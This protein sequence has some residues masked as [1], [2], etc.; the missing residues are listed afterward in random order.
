MST[1]RYSHLLSLE[2]DSMQ[3]RHIC[4]LIY[5]NECPHAKVPDENNI[6]RSSSFMTFTE[7]YQI[8]LGFSYEQNITMLVNDR[9]IKKHFRE[10]LLHAK[11]RLCVYIVKDLQTENILM[12]LT[13]VIV[14]DF[15][16]KF[17]LK[18]RAMRNN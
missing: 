14:K 9:H 13:P 10:L 6:E 5:I 18:E 11:Y 8:F 16:L 3:S 7:S 12:R 15:L 4:T 1:V 17:F 2:T